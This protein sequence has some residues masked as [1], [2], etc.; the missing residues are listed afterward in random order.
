MIRPRILLLPAGLVLLLPL[1]SACANDVG[2]D[3]PGPAVGG[4][5]PPGAA[6]SA[7]A[8]T[9]EDLAGYERG[10]RR[11]IEAVREARQQAAAATDPQERGQAMQAQWETSTIPLGAEAS[12]L[13]EERYRLVRSAV[14]EILQTLDFQGKIDGPLSM[15]LSR[16]DSATRERLSRDP[17]ND[18]NAASADVLRAGM[19]TVAP[20]WIEYVSLTAVAG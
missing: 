2:T 4:G 16:A 8:L 10:M 17:F 11:E 6:A 3:P 1:L 5:L 20:V 18:L 13:G 19:D 12:G 14:D 15:D 9:E 7:L